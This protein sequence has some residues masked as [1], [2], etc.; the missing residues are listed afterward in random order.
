MRRLPT[1]G[2]CLV[3]IVMGLMGLYEVTAK[4]PHLMNEPLPGWQKTQRVEQTTPWD[5]PTGILPV[6]KL[7]HEG[8]EALRYYGFIG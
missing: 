1:V 8:E 7:L 3:T 4:S 2:I 6:D 5:P